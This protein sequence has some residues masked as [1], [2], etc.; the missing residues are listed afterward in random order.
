MKFLGNTMTI[1]LPAVFG[2]VVTAA[3]EVYKRG[4]TNE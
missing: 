3:N 4:E 2:A 1:L